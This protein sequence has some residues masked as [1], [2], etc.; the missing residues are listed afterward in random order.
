MQVGDNRTTERAG[1]NA[2]RSLFE[3]AHCVF[4]EVHGANDYGKDAYVDLTR[5]KVITGVCIGVQVK[6][7]ASYRSGDGYAI[8]TKAHVGCWANSPIPIAGIVY[9]PDL[10]RMFWCDLTAACRQREPADE[11]PI[12]VESTQVL[13]AATLDSQFKP[14]F[15]TAARAWARETL[16]INLL[17]KDAKVQCAATWDSLALGRRDPR[18]LVLLRCVLPHLNGLPLIHAIHVLSHVTP[19]PDIFWTNE[20]WVS[21]ECRAQVRPFMRW[22]PTEVRMLI[23][24]AGDDGWHRG[25]I[26]ESI[27]MLLVEDPTIRQTLR[28]VAIEAARTGDDDVAWMAF[29]IHLYLQRGN[30]KVAFDELVAAEPALGRLEMAADLESQLAGGEGLFLFE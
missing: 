14:H 30:A 27:F 23:A 11:S 16:G 3:A 28:S 29:Y 12:R 13:D 21:E 24:A 26:G 18:H 2:A 19:H 5:D 20:N 1:V 4:Q 9:D 15:V 25:S 6:S 10:V 8:P 7:G 22:S 17:S